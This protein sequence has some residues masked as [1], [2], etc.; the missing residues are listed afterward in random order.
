MNY[1]VAVEHKNPDTVV[2]QTSITEN[3]DFAE[4]VRTSSPSVII[5]TVSPTIKVSDL[6]N[7]PLSKLIGLDDYLDSYEFDCGTP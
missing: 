3:N 4:I 7:I 6:P 1:N 2:V 5:S